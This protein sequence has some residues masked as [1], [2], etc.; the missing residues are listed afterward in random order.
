[1]KPLTL[2]DKAFLLKRTTLFSSLDLD[3]L[4][5]IADKLALAAFESNE[6]LFV[7]GEEAHRMYFIVNGEVAIYSATHALIC[8]LESGDF[9][10]EE[11]LFN[12][13][14]RAYSALS[15]MESEVLTLS[16]SNLFAIISEYPSVALGF[17]Q[18]YTSTF[19]VRPS[20]IKEENVS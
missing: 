12:N 11:S 8:Q 2:I 13:K 6:Y 1:M 9:F 15:L 5:T 4:L 10:G 20:K 14:P 18:V 3:M 19:D 17:L 16:R 7:A